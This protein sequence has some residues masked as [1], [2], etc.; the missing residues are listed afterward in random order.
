MLGY[1]P[2]GESAPR[3]LDGAALRADV[4]SGT[5]TQQWKLAATGDATTVGILHNGDGTHCLTY[6]YFILQ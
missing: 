4:C 2:A 6:S 3:C 5:T 1:I